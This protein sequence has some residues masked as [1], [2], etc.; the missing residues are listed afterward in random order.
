MGRHNTLTLIGGA[1]AL[2][3][4]TGACNRDANDTRKDAIEEDAKVADKA[5][6]VEKE[7]N[8]EIARLNERVAQLERDFNNK[9][10]VLA[11]GKRIATSSLRDEVQED[12]NNV[13][14]AVA[15]LSSTTADNWWDREEEAMRA[16]I[17]DVANDVKRLAGR[18]SEPAPAAPG[19]TTA[20][21]PFTS[22]RDG[23]VASMKGRVDALDHALDNVKAKGARETELNDTRARVKKLA[24]DLDGLAR[25]SADD[26]WSVS[27]HRVGDYLD[28]VEASV[29]RLDDN[30]PGA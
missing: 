4:A 5:A 19:E 3:L 24:A 16:T 30:K 25:A 6:A 2:A 13:R 21:A 15:N 27:R 14:Q 1:L 10:A 29:K 12:V 28:R 22:R 9:S 7:R 17:D 8:D 26:W 11:S 23:F 20:T 18:V